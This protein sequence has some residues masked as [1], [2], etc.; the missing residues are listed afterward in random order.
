MK[1]ERRLSRSGRVKNRY[2]LIASA[3]L[4]ILAGGGCRPAAI[5]PAAT[6]VQT[7][8]QTVE[9]TRLVMVPVTVTT[10]PSPLFSPTPSATPTETS[11]PTVTP[12]DT[13][14]PTITP[15]PTYTVPQVRILMHSQCRY[16]PGVAYL[17]KYDLFE[18]NRLEVIGWREILAKQTDGSWQPSVWAYLRAIGGTNPCWLSAKLFEVIKGDIYS[19]VEYTPRLP[20]SELYKPPVSVEA[21]R[22]GNTVTVM[23]SYVWMTEDDYRG[24]LVESWVCHA[25]QIYF[26]PVSYVGPN[27]DHLAL[28][29]PDEPG[30]SEPSS[31]RLYTVEKHGYTPWIPIPWP[32][33]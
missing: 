1:S 12:T 28:E 14:T 20:Y 2:V 32:G 24:Y 8:I 4:A 21:T 26:A 15:S 13:P 3:S 11:T 6:V 9:V 16:G 22:D 10:A 30:C 5:P 33:F 23:W 31:G 27:V 7:V 18:G 25:G 29:I 19:T 17:Y